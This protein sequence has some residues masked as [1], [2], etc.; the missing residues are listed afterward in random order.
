[1][2]RGCTSSCC[3]ARR[4]SFPPTY[5]QDL[6]AAQ[7]P[8]P[9]PLPRSAAHLLSDV[10]AFLISLFAVWVSQR[11]AAGRYS[12]GYH[13]WEVIGAL[14]S[15][16]LIWIL[17][18]VLC[19]E[20]VNRLLHP[21]PVDGKVMFITATAGLLV[22]L[23]M[24]RVLHQG[25]GH[26][27]GGHSHGGGG[28]HS[29][30]GHDNLNVTAAYIHVV[31]DLVQ[32]IGV[33]IAAVIIWAA[34]EAHAAD[35]ICTFLF[36]VLVLFTT[37][38]ILRSA[39]ASIL[40]AVP[41]YVS[42]AEVSRGLLALPGVRAVYALHVWEYG[43]VG[44]REKVA[45]SVHLVAEGDPAPVLAG[46]L[47]VAAAA[48]IAHPTVQ[49]E[50]PGAG[51]PVDAG[52]ATLDVFEEGREPRGRLLA[53]LVADVWGVLRG[54]SGGGRRGG[55]SG[56]AAP[57]YRLAP[58]LGSGG[59]GAHHGHSHAGGA[60]CSALSPREPA[61]AVPSPAI[62]IVPRAPSAR[63]VGG[64]ASGAGKASAPAALANI[65]APPPQAAAGAP[66]SS[67]SPYGGSD[68]SGGFAP[69]SGAGSYVAPQVPASPPLGAAADLRSPV[70]EDGSV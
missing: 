30:G 54:R 46:A 37:T 12:W 26:S 17:T 31:G 36:S 40:N 39:G 52:V 25:G 9:P 55:A 8:P 23:L 1:M 63:G 38:S 61:S 35:P 16:A 68:S 44:D 24:M 7:H 18:A 20:A 47:R 51:G 69:A 58:P 67:L 53:D 2:A 27:H 29:H 57:L 6:R 21:E 49:V 50:A 65:S 33:M 66:A 34:P 62:R 43:G 5:R 41:P 15:V 19:L 10:L 4:R 11:P 64:A 42:L 3:R 56:G 13:R 59:G 22:N 32:S 48:G 28:G 45:M 14:A 70:P 60:S